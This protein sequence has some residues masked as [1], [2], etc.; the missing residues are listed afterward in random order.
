MSKVKNFNLSR[1]SQ[2]KKAIL[3]IIMQY[4]YISY[5]YTKTISDPELR[6]LTK[7]IL[8]YNRYHIISSKYNRIF[9]EI[10]FQN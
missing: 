9:T 2:E 10:C 1:G 7:S 6:H 5:V 3:A 4:T 8:R